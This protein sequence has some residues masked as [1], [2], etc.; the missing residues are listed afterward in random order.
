[1][2]ISDSLNNAEK[3]AKNK[4]AKIK[5]DSEKNREDNL[6]LKI[7]N[8]FTLNL[9]FFLWPFYLIVFV[10]FLDVS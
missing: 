9:A 3:T 7:Y 4:F 8:Y 5:Y 6:Q 1:M 10:Y 2:R